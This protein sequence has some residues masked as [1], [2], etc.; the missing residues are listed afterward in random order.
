[1]ENEVFTFGE[2]EKPSPSQPLTECEAFVGVSVENADWV[3]GKE[4]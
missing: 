3:Q 4:K 2:S 1:M